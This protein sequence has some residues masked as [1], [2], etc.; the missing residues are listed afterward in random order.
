MDSQQRRQFDSAHR[1]LHRDTQDHWHSYTGRDNHTYCSTSNQSVLRLRPTRIK[2]LDRSVHM[3]DNNRISDWHRRIVLINYNIGVFNAICSQSWL[4]SA[5]LLVSHVDN[6][7]LFDH[8]V[9]WQKFLQMA[10]H[11][12]HVLRNR[13]NPAL[14]EN[15]LEQVRWHVDHG[16]VRVAVQSSS[17]GHTQAAQIPFPAGRLCVRE[18]TRYSQIRMASV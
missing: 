18:Y 7:I 16:G 13:K 4:L 5:L 9:A 14:P 15:T 1:W 10:D 17:L 11:A 6:T 12:W 3:A 2:L 8:V